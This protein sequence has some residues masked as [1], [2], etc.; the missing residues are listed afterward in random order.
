MPLLFSRPARRRAAASTL[1]RLERYAA[2]AAR[3]IIAASD[4]GQRVLAL[5]WLDIRAH[6]LQAAARLRAWVNAA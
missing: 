3:K 1:A 4:A 5:I 6:V 2:V